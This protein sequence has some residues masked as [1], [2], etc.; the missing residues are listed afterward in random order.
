M[1]YFHTAEL[2][3][4]MYHIFGMINSFVLNTV[5]LLLTV[6]YYYIHPQLQFI[7]L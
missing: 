7:I 1:Y 5:L 6:S 4:V 3:N 2:W